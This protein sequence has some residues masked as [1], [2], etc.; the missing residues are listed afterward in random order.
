MHVI[1]SFFKKGKLLTKE[2]KESYE[3]AKIWYIW[4]EKFQNKYIKG[5]RYYKVRDHCHHTGEC[6]SAAHSIWKWKYSVPKIIPMTSHNG[7]NYH[8]HFIIKDLAE[9]FRKINKLYS[10]NRKR[11]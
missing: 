4:K 7:S 11:S 2:R 8:Y 5:R 9:E 3:N 10:S 1:N 6:R